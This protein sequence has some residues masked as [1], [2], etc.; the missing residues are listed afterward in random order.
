MVNEQ[1]KQAT[2]APLNRTLGICLGASTV[3]MV[4]LEKAG[5]AGADAGS[6]TPDGALRVVKHSV[7]LHGGD[8]R[9]MLLAAIEEYD[10]SS[11]DR[12]AATGRRFRRFV[13]LTT[14][15]EPEAVELAYRYI[16]PDDISCP[17]I[18]SAGGRPLWS[19]FLMGRDG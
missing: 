14:I 12:I 1:L 13:N 11:I 7:H 19:T 10:I 4:L 8:P 5:S 16:K 3:S 18:V 6:G 2:A 15:A 17:A 9:R